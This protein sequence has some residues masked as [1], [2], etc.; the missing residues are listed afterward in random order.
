MVAARLVLVYLL[1]EVPFWAT[2]YIAL[3]GL[4]F[5]LPLRHVSDDFA[6]RGNPCNRGLLLSRTNPVLDEL[7]AAVRVATFVSKAARTC[8]ER[9]RLVYVA[10]LATRVSV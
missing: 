6:T 10:G 9:S 8:L 5:L 3:P 2:V 1:E 7:K 4:C